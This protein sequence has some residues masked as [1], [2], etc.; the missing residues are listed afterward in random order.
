MHSEKE[1]WGR[2]LFV[3]E[4]RITVRLRALPV[5]DE[6]NKK[7]CRTVKIC[8]R[9]K[10]KQ[11]LGTV[12]RKLR[13]TNCGFCRSISFVCRK[14]NGCFHLK[15]FCRGGSPEPPITATQLLQQLINEKNC[16]LW[17]GVET[18]PYEFVK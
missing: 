2:F 7:N 8:R 16:F 3:Q 6:A 12:G 9:S 17:S 18:R 13:M 14:M 15:Y 4:L 5:A 1:Y 11:I 10:P